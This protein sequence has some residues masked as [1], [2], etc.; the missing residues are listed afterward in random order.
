L[1]KAIARNLFVMDGSITEYKGSDGQLVMYEP[2]EEDRKLY[3]GLAKAKQLLEWN[4]QF[5]RWFLYFWFALAAV[6]IVIGSFS[7][8]RERKPEITSA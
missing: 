1:G 5:F 6:S 8:I 2:T 4:R 7:P 3:Q